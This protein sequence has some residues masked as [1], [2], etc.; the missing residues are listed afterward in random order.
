MLIDMVVS[1]G[2]IDPPQWRRVVRK[3]LHLHRP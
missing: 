3:R 2:G 1:D